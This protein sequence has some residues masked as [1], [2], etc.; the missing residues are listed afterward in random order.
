MTTHAPSTTGVGGDG[1]FRVATYI[2]EKSEQALRNANVIQLIIFHFWYLQ[3]QVQKGSTI[4]AEKKP[5]G[6][7]GDSIPIKTNV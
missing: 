5:S 6:T 2:K 4:M 7:L 1:G 3:I